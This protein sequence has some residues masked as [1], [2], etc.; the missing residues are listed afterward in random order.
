MESQLRAR[1]KVDHIYIYI[2]TQM[3]THIKIYNVFSINLKGKV[4]FELSNLI[5][6]LLKRNNLMKYRNHYF[7]KNILLIYIFFELYNQHTLRA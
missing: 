1:K 7:T 3:L 6:S 5:E 4:Y 2:N